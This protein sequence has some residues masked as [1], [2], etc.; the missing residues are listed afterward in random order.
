MEVARAPQLT[1]DINLAGIR[2]ETVES[3]KYLGTVMSQNAGMAEEVT[4]RIGAA[5]RCYYSL[6]DLF[7]RRSISRKTKLRIYNTVIRP[8]LIYGCETW[9]LTKALEKRFEVFE[10]AVLR[11]IEGPIY[12]QETNE[13]RR[14]HNREIRNSTKQPNVCDVIRSRRLQWAGHVAR[15]E[16]DRNPKRIF[17]AEVG[18]RRPVGRPRKDWRRCLEEDVNISGGNPEEWFQQAQNREEWRI[19]SRAV[20]GQQVA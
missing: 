9:S 15:M 2:I 14:R 3:F 11:R 8:L 1:G 17:L 18:G 7:K 4:A 5:N 20:M 19:L 12:D 13:W 6:T 16:E 10:N